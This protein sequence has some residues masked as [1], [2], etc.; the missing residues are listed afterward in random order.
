LRPADKLAAALA[1]VSRAPQPCLPLGVHV[2]FG[3]L[4]WRS[5]RGH[6]GHLRLLTA[7]AAA[8]TEGTVRILFGDR[9][10]MLRT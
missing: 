10:D 4:V 7:G 8:I 5:A 1:L 3:R 2:M 9:S 6:D